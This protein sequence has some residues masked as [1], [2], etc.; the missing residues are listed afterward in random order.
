MLRAAICQN[1]LKVNL[2]KLTTSKIPDI[3]P[4]NSHGLAVRLTVSRLFS[5]S[6]GQLLISHCHSQEL[7]VLG[8]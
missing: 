5:R 7:T 4:F 2:S 6:H 3:R 8:A 1:A